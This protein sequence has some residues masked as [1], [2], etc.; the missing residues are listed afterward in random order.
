MKSNL[1]QAGTDFVFL[2]ILFHILGGTIPQ[3]S[4]P[5]ASPQRAGA[6]SPA[7]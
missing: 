4:V 5:S 3:S 2:I 7:W 6:P 1:G